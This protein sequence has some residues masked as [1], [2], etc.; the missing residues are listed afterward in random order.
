[1]APYQQVLAGLAD[2]PVR[3]V[4]GAGP[5]NAERLLASARAGGGA[6]V[7]SSVVPKLTFE[8]GVLAGGLVVLFLLVGTL[9]R[10]PW[11]VVPGTVV[12]MVFFLSGALLQPQTTFLAWL[13][14][15]FGSDDGPGDGNAGPT[16]SGVDPASD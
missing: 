12:V 3:Y 8:Y 13:F 9:S 1:V 5:G 10:A 6:D 15:G 4:T 7:L 16:P 2:D 11:R 14:T